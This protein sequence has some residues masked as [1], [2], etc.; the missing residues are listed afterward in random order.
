MDDIPYQ[1]FISYARDNNL[2]SSLPGPDGS[3]RGWV[4]VFHDELTRNLI[5]N[6][7]RDLRRGQRDDGLLWIDYEQLRG[8]EHLKPEIRAK[9]AASRLFIPILS[10]RWFESPWCLDELESFLSLWP[11]APGRVFPVWRE[12]VQAEEL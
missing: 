8:G 12:P 10:R 6:L 9:L 3:C 7:S 2:P 1:G 4:E 11:D 5:E